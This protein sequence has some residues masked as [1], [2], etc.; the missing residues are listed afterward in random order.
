MGKGPEDGV[1]PRKPAWLSQDIGHHDRTQS[2]YRRILSGSAPDE[3]HDA[4]DV[5]PNGRTPCASV[6]VIPGRGRYGAHGSALHGLH[7][8]PDEVCGV[9]EEGRTAP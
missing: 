1:S 4:R 9:H 7:R 8:S 3:S 6:D 2:L 5:L